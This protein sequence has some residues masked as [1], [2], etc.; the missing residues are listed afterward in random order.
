MRAD[1]KSA[2]NSPSRCRSS[3]RHFICMKIGISTNNPA[4]VFG[5][6]P[7]YRFGLSIAERPTFHP[8]HTYTFKGRTQDEWQAKRREILR[9]EVEPTWNTAAK[10]PC[11]IHEVLPMYTLSNRHNRLV[12]PVLATILRRRKRWEKQRWGTGSF[13]RIS[14]DVMALLAE[15]TIVTLKLNTGSTYTSLA[16]AIEASKSVSNA[17]ELYAAWVLLIGNWTQ[18]V[19]SF[20]WQP[21]WKI[22]HGPDNEVHMLARANRRY[23][24]LFE[25]NWFPEANESQL[26]WP[27]NG[28]RFK[29]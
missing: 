5:W 22:D 13:T 24:K 29:Y 3:L 18:S 27:K 28:L 23:N 16:S 6:V 15:A 10:R 7:G 26:G 25:R 12:W 17:D 2:H 4:S 11:K 14:N 8:E 1:Y 20:S 19:I 21:F 9:D